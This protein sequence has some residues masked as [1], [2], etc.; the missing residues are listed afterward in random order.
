MQEEAVPAEEEL[1]RVPEL[2]LEALGPCRMVES[3]TD[4]RQRGKAKA[5]KEAKAHAMHGMMEIH[6]S[7]LRVHSPTFARNAEDSTSAVLASWAEHD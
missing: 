4:N 2:A 1:V 6:A 5:A 7:R 3:A